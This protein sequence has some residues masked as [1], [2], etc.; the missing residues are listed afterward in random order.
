ME[1]HT[2]HI[3][4]PK[5]VSITL[6]IRPLRR[7]REGAFSFATLP[8]PVHR[9]VDSISEAS[10]RAWTF[11]GKKDLAARIHDPVEELL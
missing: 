11:L 2:T 10:R 5:T 8:H 1:S 4:K 6:R 3:L 9:A 7:R